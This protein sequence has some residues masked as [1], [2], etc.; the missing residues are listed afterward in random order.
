MLTSVLRGGGE[1]LVFMSHN[2]NG[3]VSKLRVPEADATRI[4]LPSV[5]GFKA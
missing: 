2:D 4:L 5:I 1:D 3:L